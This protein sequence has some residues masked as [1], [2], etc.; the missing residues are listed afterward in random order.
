MNKN[1]LSGVYRLLLCFSVF[2]LSLLF[3]NQHSFA[4]SESEICFDTAW[5]HEKSDLIPDP[6]VLFGRLA[7]DFRYVIKTNETPRQRVA[8]YLNVQVGS[9]HEEDDE[10]GYAHFVE[11][12]LFNGST[13]F[14]PGKLIEY[15]QEIGMEFGADINAYVTHDETVYMLNLPDGEPADIQKGLLVMADYAE[16][17]LF[18]NEEVEKERGVI[19]AE[20][21]ARD[22]VAYR[23]RLVTRQ[24]AL[25]GTK[26][27]KR[28]PIGTE[29]SI[30]KATSESLHAFYDAWYRPENMILVVVGDVDVE[31]VEEEIEKRFSSMRGRGNRPICP[32]LGSIAERGLHSFYFYEEEAGNTDVAI[33]SYY[34]VKPVDDSYALQIEGL[35]E[36]FATSILEK[37]LE[38]FGE[39]NVGLMLNPGVYVG[40]FSRAFGY[41]G[42]SASTSAENWDTLLPVLE[43]KLRQALEYGISVEELDLAKADVLAFFENQVEKSD[44]RPSTRIMG[45]LIYTLNNNYV[46]QSPEQ[47]KEMFS[48]AVQNFTKAEIDATLHDL[49]GRKEKLIEVTGDANIQSDDPQ[50]TIVDVY[51]KAKLQSVGNYQITQLI[52]FPYLQLSQSS[53]QPIEHQRYEEIDVD[54]YRYANGTVLNLKQTEFESNEVNITIEFGL[55]K[56]DEPQSGM[57]MLAESVI[58][59][60]GTGRL[61]ESQLTDVLSGSSVNHWFGV[62]E[63]KFVL[64]GN[65]LTG[66]MELLIQTLQTIL[67]DPG[68][69]ENAY[70]NVMV[71]YGQTYKALENNIRGAE[72]LKIQSFLADNHPLFSVPSLDQLQSIESAMIE[73]WLR[74]IF[75]MAALE[76]SVVGDVP[77]AKVVD[78]VGRY[79]GTLPK[80]VEHKVVDVT[81]SFP[82]GEQKNFFIQSKIDQ[83]LL[84]MAWETAGFKDIGVVRRLNTLAS[85]VEERVRVAIREELG[86][87]YSPSAYNS[88]SR[89]APEYGRLTVRIVT[90]PEHFE[91]VRG[92]VK[93]ISVKLIKNGVTTEEL[94]RVINPGLTSLIDLKR[95]NRYWLNSVLAGS[96]RYPEQLVWPQTII[97]DYQAISAAEMSAYARFYLQP[98]RLAVAT[99]RPEREE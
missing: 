81:V 80:K 84:V 30:M 54:V 73:E 20:K 13:H 42:L 48:A 39:E 25:Q 85:I 37:R 87:T 69:R 82:A 67:E 66:D 55:G 70:E 76:I 43:N 32:E 24:N 11:H 46:Y 91:I 17:A 44:T 56:L 72:I 93:T 68:F 47:E 65:S 34:N 9:L 52:E 51:A 19:L 92:V 35:R 18:L 2:L 15:F 4:V 74:P 62:A 5:P 88:S 21:L 26:L 79:F 6:S 23:T 3:L 31:L 10:Q 63:T 38:R 83:V 27:A 16:G 28:P 12:M 33:E 40:E 96:T 57:G 71:S 90:D 64:G 86:A 60:S 97:E 75:A 50:R 14:P 77:K 95:T 8:M 61:T 36:Y 53:T 22:S 98:D 58:N 99:V 1:F 49:F 41:S 78:L 45:E 59:S 89:F 7:N 29:E 94:A